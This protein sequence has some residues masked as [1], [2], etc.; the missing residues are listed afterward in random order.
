MT[1]G[2]DIAP[3]L[4]AGYV[5]AATETACPD[6]PA[7]KSVLTY[8]M[9]DPIFFHAKTMEQ[10]KNQTKGLTSGFRPAGEDTRVFGVTESSLNIGGGVEFTRQ[11]RGNKH[12][13]WPTL[14]KVTLKY[15][16]EVHIA[17]DFDKK[18]CRYK[19]T[20]V[21]ELRHVRVYRKVLD[22]F[23]PKLEKKLAALAA[24]LQPAGP[25]SAAEIEEVQGYYREEMESFLEKSKNDILRQATLENTAIDSEAE[26]F[27]AS[28]ACPQELVR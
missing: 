26:Y 6:M 8:E 24:S 21:H 9:N 3:L 5:L 12:C 15:R 20:M 17:R 22:A 16:P 27:R 28:R 19:D 23:K 2:L 11:Q 14:L 25:L 7:A 1:F 13:L 10:L 4:F 18:S